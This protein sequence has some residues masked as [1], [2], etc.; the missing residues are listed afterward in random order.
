LDEELAGFV[1]KTI[2]SNFD[3]VQKKGVPSSSLRR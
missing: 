3:L 2:K 1:K